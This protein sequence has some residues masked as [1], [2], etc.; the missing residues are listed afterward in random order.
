M[1]TRYQVHTHL[2]SPGHSDC[3][4]SFAHVFGS[5][6]HLYSPPCTPASLR[7]LSLS[8][9]QWHQLLATLCIAALAPCALTSVMPLSHDDTPRWLNHCI[10][11]A[12]ATMPNSCIRQERAI[13]CSPGFVQ[14]AHAL[15][16]G[17]RIFATN[18]V[19]NSQLCDNS[20]PSHQVP[21]LSTTRRHARRISVP[22]HIHPPGSGRG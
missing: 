5:F 21:E 15:R 9:C 10:I 19:A 18:R 14:T 22:N 17:Q 20:V 11:P 4:C 16:G 3:P 1:H 6:A 7:A 12:A 8:A 2:T 13:A